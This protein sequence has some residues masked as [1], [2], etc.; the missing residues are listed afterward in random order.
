MF[1]I[2]WKLK[3]LLYKVFNIFG[4]TIFFY[5]IQKYITKRSRIKINEINKLWV[6]HSNSIEKYNVKNILEVGAGKSLAQNIYISYK[7]ENLIKQT[8]VDINLMIDFDLVNEASSQISN[9][10]GEKNKGK[11]KNFIDLKTFYN[12]DYKAPCTLEGL[13]DINKKFDMC[14][15]TTALEHFT[16]NDL[17]KYLSDLKNVL[18]KDVLISSVVDYSDHYSHTDKNIG[19]LNF[20]KY[21]EKDWEKY[22]NSYLFQNRLRHQNYKKIFDYNGYKIKEVFESQVTQIPK[23]VSDEFDAQNKE[24]YVEWAYFLIGVKQ[25]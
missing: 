9:I 15:S 21:S 14:I 24:T 13:K 2:N 11:I 5:W 1:Q 3:A 10:L 25:N 23:E 17:N 19:A 22:N 18:T 16:I 4:F 8:A 6:F 7:F 20:L 12:I